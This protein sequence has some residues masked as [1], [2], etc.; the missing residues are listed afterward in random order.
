MSADNFMF[1]TKAQDGMFTFVSLSDSTEWTY[2]VPVVEWQEVYPTLP[3]ARVRFASIGAAVAA[4]TREVAEYGV[5][6]DL[7]LAE[8][9]PASFEE[10]MAALR[11]VR[12]GHAAPLEP[13]AYDELDEERFRAAQ[14]EARRQAEVR[15]QAADAM[16]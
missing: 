15:R 3:E 8:T 16:G 9:D 14:A 7:R 10:A 1:V 2:E 5:K 6:V 13:F 12:C 4:A 11:E